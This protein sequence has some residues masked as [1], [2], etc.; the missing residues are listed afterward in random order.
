MAQPGYPPAQRLPTPVIAGIA[1]ILAVMFIGFDTAFLLAEF[2]QI[3]SRG[4]G[5]VALAA[6]PLIRLLLLLVG[7]ILLFGGKPAGRILVIIA[8]ALEVIGLILGASHVLVLYVYADYYL[9]HEITYIG[10]R[11]NE[12]FQIFDLFPLIAIVLELVAVILALLPMSARPRGIPPQR[13][14]SAPGVYSGQQ[15]GYPPPQQGYPQQQAS[16]PQQ[17]PGY[18]PAQ[19]P[20][21]Q[22]PPTPPP[23]GQG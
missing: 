16:Y 5:T 21:P 2:G 9:I 10:G 6:P 14:A 4:S 22:P 18:P 8:F 1:A 23:T 19:P 17:Q 15:P 7:A 11:F 12:Y 20:M 13:F 3:Y